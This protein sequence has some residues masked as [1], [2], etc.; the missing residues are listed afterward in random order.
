SNAYVLMQSDGAALF[1]IEHYIVVLWI[2]AA[3]F[4][5]LAYLAERFVCRPR[6][7]AFQAIEAKDPGYLMR[8][9][10]NFNDA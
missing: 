3:V 5:C 6:Y 2:I 1:Q 9:E 8:R 4:T 10:I 7:R